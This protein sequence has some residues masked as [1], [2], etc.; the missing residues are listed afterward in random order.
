MKNSNIPL[1]VLHITD[2][3]LYADSLANLYGVQ[4]DASFRAVLKAAFKNESL[5]PDLILVTG[6]IVEDS[7]PAGYER[8]RAIVGELGMPVMAL[9]GNHDNPQLMA[10]IFDQGPVSFCTTQDFGCWR[11]ILLDSHIKAD[12]GGELSVT[13]LDRLE[14]A[15]ETSAAKNVL[16]GVHHQPIEMGSRWLDGY[17]LRN[18]D[19]LFSI[20]SRY[21]NVRCMLWGHVHQASDRTVENVR[22]ISTPST[23]AQFTPGT[24]TCIMDTRPPGFRR[25]NLLPSGEI[26]TEVIWLDDWVISERPPDSRVGN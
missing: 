17:G 10:E 6:D 13:E 12:D 2:L 20:L 22:L 14:S 4:T 11:I 25:L 5:P 8:F 15:L 24:E 21:C 18:A 23:C 9:P 1:R 7:S 26:N 3:H 19:A 16:I